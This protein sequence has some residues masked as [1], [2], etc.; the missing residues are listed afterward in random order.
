M[1]NMI[2]DETFALQAAC[3][4]SRGRHT[5]TRRTQGKIVISF[6]R[7]R[8]YH[9]HRHHDHEVC[10]NFHL[11]FKQGGAVYKCSASRP[12]DCSIIP[13]DTKGLNQRH[14]HHQ[15]HLDHDD[16]DQVQRWRQRASNMTASRANGW[17]APLTAPE[18]TAPFW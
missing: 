5:T 18:K 14:N 7:H 16:D 17:A 9:Q 10:H 6:A 8:R 1:K 11:G 4:S 2:N 13:F 3:W 15:D 12:G